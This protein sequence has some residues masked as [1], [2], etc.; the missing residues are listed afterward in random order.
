M[1]NNALKL[2]A[3]Q[4]LD[5]LMNEQLIPFKLT[6][7]KVISEGSEK[8]TVRFYDSRIHSITLTLEE[9]KSFKDV[10]RT[11]TLD[12]VA[13]MSGALNRKKVN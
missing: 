2:E 13:R 12:R 3:Q 6:A 10:V 5:E 8:Y 7:E 1:P 4:A 9:G 11:A